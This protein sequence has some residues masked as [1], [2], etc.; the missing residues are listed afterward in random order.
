MIP[1]YSKWATIIDRWHSSFTGTRYPSSRHPFR[2]LGSGWI[3]A[4]ESYGLSA[5]VGR[6]K[7]AGFQCFPDLS[8]LRN[9]LKSV[10]IFWVAS[11]LEGTYVL[12]AVF[13]KNEWRRKG[14]QPGVTEHCAMS[15]TLPWILELVREIIFPPHKFFFRFCRGYNSM[16]LDLGHAN[17]SCTA[18]QEKCLAPVFLTLTLRITFALSC[19]GVSALHSL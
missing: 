19:L 17:T 4:L 15:E 18:V 16:Q 7:F 12:S 1:R 9:I 13:W 10:E 2:L 11:D 14:N 5:G 8:S 6:R 3:L